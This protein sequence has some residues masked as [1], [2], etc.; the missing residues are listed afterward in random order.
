MSAAKLLVVD[1][2][3][4]S[5]R[6]VRAIVAAH[7]IGTVVAAHDGQ[8]GLDAVTAET[9]DVVILDLG[10]PRVPGLD[11]LARLRTT[12]PGL[13]VIVLTADNQIR[14]AVVATEKGAF[15]FL[16]KPIDGDELAVVVK[17]AL[18]SRALK[19]EVEALRRRLE[20]G[21]TLA[22]L[23][24]PSPETRQI[25]EQV[26]TVA[27][28]NFTV[29]V[30]GETGT[31]KELI[32]EAIHRGSE[33][34][35]KPFLALDCGALEGTLLDSTVGG[36]D[37]RRGGRG[38]LAEGGTLFLDEVSNMPPPVQARLLRALESRQPSGVP[39][40]P[41]PTRFI[42]ASSRDLHA[43]V[44]AG[45]FGADLYFRLAQYT[46]HL[47]PLRERPA[48]IPHLAERFLE[49]ASFELRHPVQQIP[50][51]TMDLLR[52]HAWPGNVR[53]LRNVIRQAVLESKDLVLRRELVS[54]VLGKAAAASSSSSSSGAE[55]AAD[56]RSL[57]EIAADAAR[58]AERQAITRALR[59]AN[60]NKSVAAKALRTDY[61]TL[62]VKMKA[63]GIRARDFSG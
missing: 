22:R 37:R 48:D 46:I 27:A 16:T 47:P 39:A 6:V 49:E 31:G 2:D 41:P 11:V 14:T 19:A 38:R 59:V 1:D 45:N 30:V 55:G 7:G 63:L 8:A 44:A 50:D 58:A 32:A 20:E 33:R 40:A 17:R 24:G 12:H 26:R 34:H 35:D 21:G 3:Q 29:L 5:C 4:T 51:D 57:R 60:G 53:E 28:T 36:A 43:L 42:A 23:M 52:R 15:H 56:D 61:K 25:L 62:H 54:A 9:P 18:E 13:P 10:L